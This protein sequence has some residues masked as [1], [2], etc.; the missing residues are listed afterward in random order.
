MEVG[1]EYGENWEWLYGA[2]F[3]Y[4]KDGKLKQKEYERKIQE[5][6]EKIEDLIESD[7]GEKALRVIRR[8]QSREDDSENG[9]RGIKASRRPTAE[10]LAKTAEEARLNPLPDVYLKGGH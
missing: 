8:A 10:D 4:D 5:L 6:K 2:R 7:G 3:G 1:R 9:L